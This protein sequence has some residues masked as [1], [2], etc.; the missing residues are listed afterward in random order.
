MKCL[1]KQFL[2][3]FAKFA[4][5]C[6]VAYT[7]CAHSDKNMLCVSYIDFGWILLNCLVRVDKYCHEKLD[8]S[9]FWIF[10]IGWRRW[11][12]I[13]M[14]NRIAMHA[15]H[16]VTPAINSRKPVCHASF[17]CANSSVC[18]FLFIFC[19]CLV[20]LIVMQQFWIARLFKQR[21][22]HHCTSWKS[23]K[24]SE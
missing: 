11:F 18:V 21:L 19:W 1:I 6:L 23:S 17:A 9:L 20:T 7:W 14:N 24:A 15:I 8:D 22:S 3:C 5:K 4:Y 13:S 16:L 2:G 12:V 10:P